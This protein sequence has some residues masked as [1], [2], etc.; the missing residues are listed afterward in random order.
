ML[1]LWSFLRR[2]SAFTFLNVLS[3]R[4]FLWFLR[5]FLDILF[6]LL[7][8]LS[9]F[10]WLRWFFRRLFLGL[11][12]RLFRRLF[13]RLFRRLLFALLLQKAHAF[14]HL[15]EFFLHFSEALH[16]L[17][18]SVPGGYFWKR[19]HLNFLEVEIFTSLKLVKERSQPEV[20][21]GGLR[22]T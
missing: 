21:N 4:D 18:F 17:N 13:W 8:S 12:R 14:G 11:F 7:L 10:L 3:F 6:L 15:F 19:R 1:S 9:F 16:L 22:S 2:F 5:F 20:S